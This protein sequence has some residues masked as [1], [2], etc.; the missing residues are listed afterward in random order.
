MRNNERQKSS[1]IDEPDRPMA[2]VEAETKV[3]SLCNREKEL[4]QQDR[5]IFDLPLEKRLELPAKHQ[6]LW[7]ERTLPIV[8]RLAREERER[9]KKNNT[10]IRMLW[11][12][13]AG[14]LKARNR[15]KD[16]PGEAVKDTAAARDG[17][18][19]TDRAEDLAKTV[20]EK[21]LNHKRAK[22]DKFIASTC[23]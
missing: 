17:G 22:F 7:Y 21:N 1:S 12:K 4:A 23:S 16:P 9:L 18:A 13:V 2:V 3:K 14:E 20:R 11:A 5:K 8:N 15:G 19:K 6:E 10:D